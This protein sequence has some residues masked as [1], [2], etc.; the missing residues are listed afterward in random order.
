MNSAAHVEKKEVEWYLRA[1]LGGN[2]QAE[3][4][5]VAARLAARSAT[6]GGE[7]VGVVG[8]GL[9]R[10]WPWPLGDSKLE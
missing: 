9:G 5:A 6:I 10:G 1:D 8:G 4:V 7:S 3:Y 2:G